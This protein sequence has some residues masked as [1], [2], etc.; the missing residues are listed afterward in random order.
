ML[1][2]PSVSVRDAAFCNSGRGLL[3]RTDRWAYIQYKKG[4]EEIFDMH[5]D[6]KQYV[7]LV[8]NP[9]YAE[10]LNSMREMLEAKLKAVRTNDL[11]MTY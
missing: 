1:D 11:G 9:E 8:G 2:D 6:P 10:A 3:L 5:K 7:N 4:E